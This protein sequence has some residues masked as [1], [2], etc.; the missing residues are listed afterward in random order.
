MFMSCGS[1]LVTAPACLASMVAQVQ[2]AANNMLQCCST[3]RTTRSV[4]P[5]SKTICTFASGQFLV[6]VHRGW[7]GLLLAIVT[8]LVRH[9]SSAPPSHKALSP[10]FFIVASPGRPMPGFPIQ[11]MDGIMSRCS[12]DDLPPNWSSML[13]SEAQ[14]HC[15][16]SNM[17]P[18]R[19]APDDLGWVPR[20]IPL[21]S[22]FSVGFLWMVCEGRPGGNQT[23]FGH[24][25][26]GQPVIDTWLSVAFGARD[27]P[28][29]QS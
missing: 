28:I 16:L 2:L 9:P 8:R 17:E 4:T 22:L 27:V 15:L 1:H 24:P 13:L 23:L 29:G 5:A 12:A 18:D 7:K 20:M 14:P 6:C 25:I 19:T 3:A 26:L 21:G 11:R 10:V